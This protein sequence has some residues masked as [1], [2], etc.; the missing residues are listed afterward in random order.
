MDQ[1]GIN[2]VPKIVPK[3]TP[4]PIPRA[5]LHGRLKPLNLL[6]VLQFCYIFGLPGELWDTTFRLK[7]GVWTQHV[8]QVGL[9]A[10]CEPPWCWKC[11]KWGPNLGPKFSFSTLEPSWLHLGAH[12]PP[13]WP[14]D[15]L[16]GHLGTVLLLFLLR[17]CKIWA[18][19]F[20]DKNLSQKMLFS[21]WL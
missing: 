11:R 10:S 9:Q 17:K 20:R 13:K 15:P 14:Q 3:S 2:L 21:G 12:V 18:M 16:R 1:L 8:I 5:T 6:T 19:I 4:R 7:L